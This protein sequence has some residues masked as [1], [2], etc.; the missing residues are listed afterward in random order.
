MCPGARLR[1][2]SWAVRGPGRCGRAAR[3]AT[4]R[5]TSGSGSVTPGGAAVEE[6]DASRFLSLLSSEG[7]V[8]SSFQFVD[9]RERWEVAQS[10]LGEARHAHFVVLP[11]SEFDQWSST[12]GDTLALDVPIVCLCHH[13][14]RSRR[15]CEFLANQGYPK[16]FNVT[17]GI[18]AVS[19]LDPTVPPY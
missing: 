18:D 11:L 6:L 2:A 5:A 1:L 9:V 10:N 17:G 16:L 14:V 8:A 19:R 12:L 13:G 15:M 3:P 7:D 4:G